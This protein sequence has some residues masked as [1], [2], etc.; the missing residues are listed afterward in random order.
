MKDSYTI[1]L[2]EDELQILNG[3]KNALSSGIPEISKVYTATNG[4]IALDLLREKLPDIIITDLRMPVMG[5]VDFVRRT[6]QEGFEQP[7]LILTAIEDFQTAQALIPYRIENYIVKPF[8]IKEITEETQR[9]I[10]IL[11]KSETLTVARELLVKRPDLVNGVENAMQNPLVKEAKMYIKSNLSEPLTL[12]S[13]VDRLH[14]S[15][16][17]LSAL[18]KRETGLTVN[19]YI[20]KQ[21]MNEAKRLLSE[22]DLRV[23]EICEIIG[24]QSD[25]YFI[26]VFRENE[27]VTPL[28]FRKELQQQI[29]KK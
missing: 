22:T 10:S 27:G 3:M 20:T 12:Q 28:T 5:G 18:F 6:R 29:N 14:I 21:R 13:I 16:S 2:V 23:G 25:K 15:K 26:Q 11:R 24:Y 4:S 9:I 8:S 1:L 7:I 17:Y 19:D